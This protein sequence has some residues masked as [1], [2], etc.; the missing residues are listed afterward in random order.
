MST[1]LALAI[2]CDTSRFTIPSFVAGTLTILRGCR[3]PGNGDGEPAGLVWGLSQG[4][5]KQKA[6]GCLVEEVT[7][8]GILSLVGCHLCLT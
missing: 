1:W 2:I 3:A 7:G 8:P 4:P 6:P 5:T